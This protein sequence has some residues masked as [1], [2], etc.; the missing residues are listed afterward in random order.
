MQRLKDERGAVAVMVALLMVPML[1]FA[2]LGVDIA[3]AYVQRQQ[4]QTG[5]DAAAFA[6]A[7]KCGRG[8]CAATATAQNYAAANLH[9][10]SST[11][12]VTSLTSSAVTVTNSGVRQHLF[13]PIL[14]IDSTAINTQ[15]HRGL[16]LA[17]RRSG[18]TAA[19]LLDLRMEGTDGWR[20]AFGNHR[21]DHQPHQELGL[22]QPTAP[23]PREIWCPAASVGSPPTAVRCHTTSTIAGVLHSDPGNSVP[24]SCA[25]SDLMG[26]LNRTVLLPIFDQYTGT[27]SNA[28]YRIYGY[29]AFV[30]TGY[31]FG[32]QNNYNDPCNGNNRCIKGYFARFVDLSEAFDFGAG[33]PQLGSSII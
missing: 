7:Q 14:G 16:G 2:A 18:N 19:G 33:A 8:A 11:A 27:G 22:T 9:S 17:D 32:G 6:I 3:G 15:R 24:S 4:L 12:T 31:H 23:V 28:T 20:D 25:Q 1:G 29:A 10:G 26:S 5:A 30:V 13:A 21:T